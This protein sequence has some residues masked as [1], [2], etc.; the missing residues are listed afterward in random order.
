[1][2]GLFLSYKKGI[3]K[4]QFGLVSCS[5]AIPGVPGILL[6]S[7]V[8]LPPQSEVSIITF[9]QVVLLSLIL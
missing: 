4:K 3:Q 8:V 1:M 5:E 9:V 2:P 6:K 7:L